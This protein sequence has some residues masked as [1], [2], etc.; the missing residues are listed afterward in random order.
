M[1]QLPQIIKDSKQTRFLVDGRPFLILGLQWDC[2]SC[3]T[4][5]EM[6]PLFPHAARMGANTVTLP[7]YWREIEPEPD[8]YD[9]RMLDE[10]ITQ[11][12]ANGLRVIPLWF[13][14]WK[15]ACSFYAPD[16]I[17]LDDVTYQAALDRNGKPT[18]S[19][20]YNAEAT[21]QRDQAA[22]VKM[23]EHIKQVDGDHTVIMVQVENEPGVL[24]SDRCYCPTCNKLFAEGEY[25]EIY[26]ANAAE[27][28][29]VISTAHYI[30][31][32]AGEAKAV[33]PLPMYQNVWQTPWLGG[34]PGREW[35]SGGAVQHM[36]DLYLSQIKNLD[37]IAPDVYRHG[38][39][40]FNRFCE[41]YRRPNNPLYIAEH[42]SSITGRAER[43][44]FYA[45]GKHGAIGFDPWAIDSPFPER[46]GPPLVDGASY[47]WGPQAYWL[48]DSYL[49][50]GRAIEPIV[51]AQDTER[52]FTFVQEPGDSGASWAAQGCDVHV[53]YV[54]RD[55]AARGIIIQRAANE[56]LIIGVGCA[57]TFRRP[58]P[59]SSP[60]PIVS[61]QWGRFEQ[62]RWVLIHH[63]RRE[64]PE[65]AGWPITHL[66]PGVSRVILDLG[67]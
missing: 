13:A 21:W 17:R 61:A 2:D 5:E 44:V 46:D 8:H 43:N 16:Y 6:N 63:M 64:R 18:V 15:N 67:S 62:D 24:G 9:F 52:I 38:Y 11:A 29:S 51:E 66:E 25:E 4:P 40:D 34:I 31:R 37:I 3:F 56:F 48:Q 28:F 14:T 45:I 35:P 54:H 20:C 58:R 26:G 47:Q 42:S 59:D 19:K 1:K 27:A 49:A 53:S 36:L 39:Q 23:M 50:I 7:T 57:I 55:N 32:L 60:I 22:L 65:A 30:D 12:R 10:R 33:L 41:T